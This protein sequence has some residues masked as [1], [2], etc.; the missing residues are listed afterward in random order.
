[1]QDHITP[2][3]NGG[4]DLG[5]AATL[6][7]VAD[8]AYGPGEPTPEAARGRQKARRFVGEMLAVI[9]RHAAAPDRERLE[10]RL[11]HQKHGVETTGLA[12]RCCQA[13]P[14][15]TLREVFARADLT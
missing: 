15:A 4:Y 8:I 3:A 11:R 14:P 7:V 9:A 2:N 10:K 12:I 13:V 6:L 1:M 5:P